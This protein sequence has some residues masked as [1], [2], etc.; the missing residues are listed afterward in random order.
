MRTVKLSRSFYNEL[1]ALLQQGFPKFGA[2]VVSEKRA[3][4]FDKIENHLVQFPNIPVDRVLGICAYPV[5]NTPFVLLYD[6]DDRELRMHLIIHTS[7][8]RTLIDLS[9]VVW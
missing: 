2:L 4:V 3:L 8:D 1:S 5:H 6:Y 9:A 7:A